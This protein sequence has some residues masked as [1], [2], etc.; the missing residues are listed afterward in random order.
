MT[1]NHFQYA[2]AKSALNLALDVSGFDFS[3][4][5]Y[6]LYEYI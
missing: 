2:T 1:C 3:I 4:E 6:D 5:I